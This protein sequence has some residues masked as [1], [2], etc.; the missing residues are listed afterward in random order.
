MR[1]DVI[2]AALLSCDGTQNIHTNYNPGTQVT[3]VVCLADAVTVRI[4][5]RV[6]HE[7]YILAIKDLDPETVEQIERTVEEALYGQNRSA[8]F[9]SGSN[10][11]L[12]E[13][14]GCNG[15]THA[16]RSQDQNYGGLLSFS[17][18]PV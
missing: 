2:G 9:K 4:T 3:S 11:G 7:K 14:D 18:A 5:E 6:L 10:K 13:D 15:K 8:D 17:R 16:E 1:L 12:R